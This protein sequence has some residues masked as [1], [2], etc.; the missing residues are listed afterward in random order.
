MSSLR[1]VSDSGIGFV[2]STLPDMTD[3][4]PDNDPGD[5]W[6]RLRD[7]DYWAVGTAAQVRR[8]RGDY[9]DGL[10][11]FRPLFANPHLLTIA[12]NFWPRRLDEV[13]FPV[14]DTLFETEPGVR[15][16]I[17]TQR[18]EEPPR[19]EIVFVHGLEGSSE[20]GYMR[21]AAQ[22]A[23]AAG[24]VA[25]RYNIR[26]CG[27]TE[28]LSPTLYHS[29]LTSDL[30]VLLRHLHSEGR[31]PVCLA[32]FSLGGNTVLKLAADLGEE[33]P[34]LVAA[35]CALSAPIDLAACARRLE[36]P[37]NRLYHWRFLRLMKERW[38]RKHR[39][40]PLEF[41]LNGL[42]EVKTLREFD[43]RFTAPSFGFRD[44]AHYYG[45]QSAKRHLERVRIPTLLIQAEDD[46]LIPFRVFDQPAVHRNPA[47]R[48]LATAHGGHLGF[49]SRHTP[50]FWAD[51]I[52]M[53]W[54]SEQQR[55]KQATVRVN[56][57]R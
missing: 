56:S 10:P 45:T 42:D 27:G 31:T 53:E 3:P 51:T 21:S 23:L 55:N 35:V 48:L 40:T 47:I 29:G 6:H 44:A 36:D 34:V 17:R 37:E 5:A 13:R 46:P 41:P 24:F 54:F 7:T 4:S 19:G 12:A 22:A 14:E 30:A 18:P 32:G 43:D 57:L 33:A 11:P 49:L 26:S 16:L 52:M 28:H 50:R 39:T 2:Q 1:Q 20:G 9:N 8:A 38:R 15:V 25:H